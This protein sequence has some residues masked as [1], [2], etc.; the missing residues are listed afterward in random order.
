MWKGLG[1]NLKSG[2]NGLTSKISNNKHSKENPNEDEE[3]FDQEFIN[4]PEGK[5]SRNN[6]NIFS[7]EEDSGIPSVRLNNPKPKN[8]KKAQKGDEF[9]SAIPLNYDENTETEQKVTRSLPDLTEREIVQTTNLKEEIDEI[10]GLGSPN[11]KKGSS[12]K[13]KM[14]INNTEIEELRVSLQIKEQAL[15]QFAEDNDRLLKEKNELKEQVKALEEKMQNGSSEKM[16]KYI[17]ESIGQY[18]SEIVNQVMEELNKEILQQIAAEEEGEFSEE[19]KSLVNTFGV[20]AEMVLRVT[21]NVVPVEQIKKPLFEEEL[22]RTRIEEKEEEIKFLE[23]K[24]K[25][26][27]SSKEVQEKEIMKAFEQEIEEYKIMIQAKSQ[28]IERIIIDNDTKEAQIRS[29]EER[30][31]MESTVKSEFEAK[32]EDMMSENKRLST[33]IS[34][35]IDIIQNLETQQMNKEDEE[36]N[37]TVAQEQC[38]ILQTEN[39]SLREQITELT[40]T[41]DDLNSTIDTQDKKL[42]DLRATVNNHQEVENRY[43]DEMSLRT[44]ETELLK[45]KLTKMQEELDGTNGYINRLEAETGVIPELNSKLETQQS[46]I[47]TLKELVSE[48]DQQI[49]NLNTSLA[50]LQTIIEENQQVKENEMRQYIERIEGLENSKEDLMKEKEAYEELKNRFEALEKE[51][52]ECGGKLKEIEEKLQESEKEKIGIKSEAAEVV[53]KV[54]E[55]TQYNENLVD[56]RVLSTFLIKYYDGNATASVRQ[57]IMETMSSLLGF[58]DEERVKVGLPRVKPVEEE[59][60]KTDDNEKTTVP[61]KSL[62]QMFMSFL[63]D[64]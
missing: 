38:K 56:K 4:Q 35:Q 9:S 1:T 23:A 11:K 54:K 25:E 12:K 17:E 52:L 40:K 21:E 63:Q 55:G 51:H 44:E 64:E 31:G 8:V 57:G 18:K 22:L 32:Y 27:E 59:E 43:L 14:M 36:S 13:Q 50:G 45:A 3:F 61:Q 39:E 37:T 7:L 6:N 49:E 46:Q 28:D 47:M 19:V 62:K 26:F 34:A 5:L 2:L 10:W 15:G 48:K 60:E 58:S 30:L 41:I 29:L 16:Q 24:L 53:K 20:K 33:E 42:T